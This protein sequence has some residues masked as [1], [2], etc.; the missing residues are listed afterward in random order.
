MNQNLTEKTPANL[1]VSKMAENLIGS[2]IIKLASEV[3]TKIKNGEKIY[4]LTIGDFN[5]KIFPIPTELK[6]EIIQAYQNEETNYPPANG[7]A[8]LRQ[9]VSSFIKRYT[10]LE[11]SA[12][13][14]LIAGGARP[15]IYAT[16]KALIDPGDVVLFPVPSW[17]NNH[18]CHLSEA[19][20]VFIE[21]KAENNFMPSAEELQPYIANAQMLALCSPLNPTG[22]TFTKE[23]LKKICEMVLE[24]NKRRTHGEKPLYILYDQIYWA[25]TY[26]DTKHY[27]PISLYP[28]LR[29]YTIFIDGLS[30]AFAGTGVRV[31]WAFGPQ[32]IIDKMKSIL[33][34]IGAWAAKAE[35][36]ASAK[37]L[38][39][40]EKTDEFLIAFRGQIQQRLQGYYAGFL[41]LK[42][43]GFEVN[44][45][46]PQA[47]IYLT[48]QL[49]L[50]GYTT[51]QNTVLTNT[52]DITKYILDEAK[53]AIVPFSAFGAS[54]DSTWY[55]ISV[56]TSTISDIDG[57]I[58]NLRIALKK[59]KK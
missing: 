25:L 3:T 5:P 33:G 32:R 50:H 21:T 14:I 27:D 37:Y 40:T 11:Y 34:H 23:G 41:A 7:I 2:E 4:N 57:V 10:D 38:N 6:N 36:V 1:R 16:Y 15:L 12:D 42:S 59:L 58:S 19:Q 49:N 20:Q 54:Q 17:N 51:D 44:A 26:G 29:D 8:E 18:Y 53:I 39:N 22:T 31:G 45:I 55:R 28:E 24:E 46:A 52:S 9:A 43:E 13:E 48:V 35:Q 56:G 47:A 30:K